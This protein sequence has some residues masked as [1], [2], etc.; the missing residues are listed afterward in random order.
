MEDDRVQYWALNYSI[1]S[2]W[3]NIL[4]DEGLYFSDTEVNS[5]WGS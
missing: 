5:E 2:T 4:M 3:S 1:F